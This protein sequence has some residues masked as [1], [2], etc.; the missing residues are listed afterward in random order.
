MI[1]A[2]LC[3]GGRF[4]AEEI[5]HPFHQCIIVMCY[6]FVGDIDGDPV[7]CSGSIMRLKK[8][9]D[10]QRTAGEYTS[11]KVLQGKHAGK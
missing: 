9:L 10:K 4:I 7:I 2:R 1:C 5:A 3:K 11:V 8:R 6:I